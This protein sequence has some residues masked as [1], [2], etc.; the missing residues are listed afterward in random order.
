M[1]QWFHIPRVVSE[2]HIGGFLIEPFIL[3]KN[4]VLKKWV[5]QKQIVLGRT[6]ALQE[7]LSWNLYI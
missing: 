3:Q 2:T 6:S 4:P 1:V 7:E 5:L